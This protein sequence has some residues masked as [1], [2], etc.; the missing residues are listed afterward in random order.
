MP[1]PFFLAMFALPAAIIGTAV[2][3]AELSRR[4]DRRTEEKT[5]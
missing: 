1:L 3:L 2:L 4:A 5:S